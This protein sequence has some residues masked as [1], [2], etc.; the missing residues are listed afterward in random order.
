MYS[1]IACLAIS[2]LEVN[3]CVPISMSISSARLSGNLNDLLSCLF[4][5]DI[6]I[7]S[8]IVIHMASTLL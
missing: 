1:R 6:G 4:T 2:D 8:L 5:S 3:P 7:T